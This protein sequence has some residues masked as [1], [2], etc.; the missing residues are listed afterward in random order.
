M[1]VVPAP[2]PLIVKW[3]VMSRSPAAPLF[4]P[5]PGMVSLKRPA[6]KTTVSAMPRKSAAMMAERSEI[7]PRHPARPEVHGHRVG[8][9]ID[10]ERG[11][12]PAGLPGTRESA[13]RRTR[14]HPAPATHALP[15]AAIQ[16]ERKHWL[17]SPGE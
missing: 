12:A 4:S 7:F 9:G 16:P 5:V 15:L 1:M 13:L 2:D 8:G 11:R 6:G 17:L 3:L 14:T 10:Q